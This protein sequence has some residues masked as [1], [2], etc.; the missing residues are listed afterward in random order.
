MDTQRLSELKLP[1]GRYEPRR[2]HI[3]FKNVHWVDETLQ[4]VGTGD[5]SRTQPDT[6]AAKLADTEMLAL[7]LGYVM[8][9]HPDGVQYDAPF[10][11]VHMSAL[12]VKNEVYIPGED[13]TQRIDREI[14]QR[15]CIS[16]ETAQAL[17]ET[18]VQS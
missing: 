8:N 4:R 14:G 11:A 5:I 10:I 16:P 13:G 9:S 1:L 3:G 2:S 17:I 6:I 12:I 7:M 18:I 15:K